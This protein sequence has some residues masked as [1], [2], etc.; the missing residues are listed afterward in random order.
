MD[1]NDDA[2][3]AAYNM[4]ILGVQRRSGGGRRPACKSS[5]LEARVKRIGATLPFFFSRAS[6]DNFRFRLMLPPLKNRLLNPEH[7]EIPN[8]EKP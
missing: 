2:D 5:F 6:R 7:G 3:I 1:G 8:P 4:A